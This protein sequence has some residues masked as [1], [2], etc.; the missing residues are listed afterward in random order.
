MFLI[1]LS[2]FSE[3]YARYSQREQLIITGA[4]IVLC[5]GAFNFLVFEQINAKK[6]I[7]DERM[8][9]TSKD[10]GQ[11]EKSLSVLRS[12]AS[13][14]PNVE[15]MRQIE[16]LQSDI[17]TYERII[18]KRTGSMIKPSDVMIILSGILQRRKG[19][20]IV[21]IKTIPS[22]DVTPKKQQ[23]IGQTGLLYKHTWDFTLRG[24]YSTLMSY[25]LAVEELE[26]GI[27]WGEV[28]ID[29]KSHPIL[30]AEVRVHTFSSMDSA[31]GV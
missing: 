7:I 27:V 3:L 22:E 31:L 8:I 2:K 26:Q 10:I 12:G 13:I 24:T 5:V 14:D 17:T 29:S 25:F 18:T 1:R 9:S 30:E 15:L 4:I 11:L 19:I 23:D 20:E 28:K 6:N 16:T 21:N